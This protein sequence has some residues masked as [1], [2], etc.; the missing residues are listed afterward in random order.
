MK[1]RL[2]IRDAHVREGRTELESQTP[3]RRERKLIRERLKKF[4]T[5]INKKG[6][7]NLRGKYSRRTQKEGEKN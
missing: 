7:I 2:E 1:K 5:I 3:K 6:E 4:E